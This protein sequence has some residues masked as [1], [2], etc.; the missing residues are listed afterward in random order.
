VE[1][2]LGV[3]GDLPG[4]FARAKVQDESRVT[5]ARKLGRADS[6]LAPTLTA[7]QARARIHG[8]TPWPGV[9]VNLGGLT[10]KLLR[11]MDE[12]AGRSQT[13]AEQSQTP[14]RQSDDPAPA[15]GTLLDPDAGLLA[16]AQGTVLRVLEAQPAGGRAMTW[17]DLRRGAARTLHAGD[18]LTQPSEPP[19]SGAAAT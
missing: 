2:V 3:L 13:P 1:L 7:A 15:F 8:L 10:L 5:K 16:M 19:R 14:T 17:A 18:T 6:L 11:V 12:P 9:S 4:A